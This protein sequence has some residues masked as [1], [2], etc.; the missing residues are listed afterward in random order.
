MRPGGGVPG[1]AGND[2]PARVRPAQL[3]GIPPGFVDR[4]DALHRLDTSRAAV[5]PHELLTKPV[6]APPRMYGRPGSSQRAVAG[7]VGVVDQVHR[8]FLGAR[9]TR[10][11]S[12]VVRH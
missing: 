9:R 10:V 1:G 5:S 12:G 8:G 2:E 4:T 7:P 3:P 6:L 11:D